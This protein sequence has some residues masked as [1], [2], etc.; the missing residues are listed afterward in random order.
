M[1]DVII[2]VARECEVTP[3]QLWDNCLRF[4]TVNMALIGLN[5]EQARERMVQTYG[6]RPVDKSDMN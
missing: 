2:E 6:E 4:A 1:T 5:A 3:G